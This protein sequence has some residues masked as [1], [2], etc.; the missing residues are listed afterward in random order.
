[1]RRARSANRGAF[2]TGPPGC[3]L[4]DHD[5]T[6]TLGCGSFGLLAIA[7]PRRLSRA[8][9]RRLEVPETAKL[10]KMTAR[11][12]PTEIRADLSKLSAADRQVLAKLVQ[13]SK[14]ID[15]L[16]LRQVW[17][18]NDAML[19]DLARDQTAEGRARLHYFLINK[20]PWSRLDHNQPFVAR[21]AAQTGRRELL[22]RGRDEG[23]ARDAGSSRCRRPSARAPPASSP[24]F[25]ARR[26]AA[27]RW[28]PTT[29]S[30]RTS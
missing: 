22:S 27:S 6:T 23:R 19:L 14:I 9:L 18:G 11:F 15:A 24:W 7:L 8:P 4:E 29:S 12:A 26:T 3:R 21:R 10:Q 20:G 16:F 28:C 17:A 2:H 5:T 30:I 13:A 25:A 1:M